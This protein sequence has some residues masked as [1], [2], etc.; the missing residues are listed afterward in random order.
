MRIRP[1]ESANGRS[2]FYF[3][4]PEGAAKSSRLS[5]PHRAD[6]HSAKLRVSPADHNGSAF[7]QTGF[8][9]RRMRDV[10]DHLTALMHRGAQ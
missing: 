7:L 4:L 1:C 6:P 2:R 9:R 5:G 10:P 8:L 3:L